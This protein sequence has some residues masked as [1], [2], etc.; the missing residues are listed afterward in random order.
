LEFVRCAVELIQARFQAQAAIAIECAPEALDEL[1]PNLALHTLIENAIKH[2]GLEREPVIRVRARIT[3]TDSALEI[4]VEDNGP[5]IQD[6][7]QAMANG[8]GLTN[9]KR[10]LLA[11]YGERHRFEVTNRPEGG[12]RVC[13]SVPLDEPPSLPAL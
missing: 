2:H 8:V 1:M 9:T 10:R 12:L 4:E 11:L 5:G 7:D 13:V 6:L 3:R